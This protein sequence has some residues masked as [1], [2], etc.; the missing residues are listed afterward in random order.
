LPRRPVSLWFCN[1]EEARRDLVAWLAKWEAKYP[2]LCE[3]VENNAA[4]L[5]GKRFQASLDLPVK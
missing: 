5:H 4:S 2:K 3:W 1:V